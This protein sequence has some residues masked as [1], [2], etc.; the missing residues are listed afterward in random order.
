MNASDLRL[1]IESD[2]E[3]LAL[4]TAGSDDA[5]AKRVNQIVP[6]QLTETLWSYR[7]LSSVVSLDTLE[8]LI[9]SVD[10]HIAASGA[11]AGVVR[12]MREYLRKDGLDISHPNT[13]VMLAG[14]AESQLPLT[15]DD[16]A[17]I[18]EAVSERPTIATVD[19]TNLGLYEP[20]Q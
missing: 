3:A 4:A 1:L 7:G 15:T 18:I 10:G 8:N 17:A 19:I 6:K 5:C 13:L 11:Y 20:A 16:V 12:E 9:A 14:W 2:A